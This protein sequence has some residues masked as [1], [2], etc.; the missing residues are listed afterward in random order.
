MER[1]VDFLTALRDNPPHDIQRLYWLARVTLVDRLEA[2]PV[3]DA[4]FAS[5]FLG[6]PPQP[7]PA[8]EGESEA[9][10]PQGEHEAAPMVMSEGTG[11]SASIH[12]LRHRRA[13]GG[14][15][16]D[17]AELRRALDRHLPKIRS[18]RRRPDRRGQHLDLRRTLRHATRTGE[19]TTLAR[20]GRP[21]RTRPLLVLI[22]VSGSLREHTPDYLRFA[23]AARCEA[24]TFGTRLTRVTRQLRQRDVARAL[25][26]VSAV[27]EDADG[28]T[29]IG[30]AL[31]E[32]VS[33]PR[34]ADRA[35][36]ALV[37]VLSDGLERGDPAQMAAAVHRLARLSHRLLWWSPLAL[38]PEYEPVTRG[39]A[40]I[41]GDIEL[42]GARDIQTLMERV[43]EL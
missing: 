41:L 19:I 4:V 15:P 39:M 32:F 25:A 8:E 36:G 14:A 1:R 3:F 34:Y 28:G 23:W 21:L 26:E 38:H 22:D 33:T 9:P 7:A 12:E 37:I 27:V 31:H 10:E 24:F 16:D 20:R 5:F 40:A 2:I 29:R 42:A 43:R 35:R 30:P 6:A 17:L 13:Y 11:K 18:R